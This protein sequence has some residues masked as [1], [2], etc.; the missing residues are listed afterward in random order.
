MRLP[1]LSSFVLATALSFNA[2]SI[3]ACGASS[4]VRLQESEENV[5]AIS[6]GDAA[7]QAVLDFLN[8]DATTFEILDIDVNLDARAARYLIEA[9]AGEDGEKGSVDDVAFT[10]IAQVDAV[11]YVGNAAL[12]SL[13]DFALAH[14]YGDGGG[15]VDVDAQD[16]AVL[17]LVNDEATD[18]FRLDEGAALNARAAR[19]IIAER[20]GEDALF[21][22]DDDHLFESIAALDAVSYVGEAA[23]E[24]LQLFAIA[25][26]YF[27]EVNGR[28]HD[29]I[30]SPQ[31]YPLSHNAEVRTLIESAERTLDIAMYSFSDYSIYDV[32]EEAVARGVQIRFIFETAN[33]DRKKSGSALA[34]TRSARLENMGVNVRY[35]NRIM[36]H[37][38][39]IVDGP[40]GDEEY[41]SKSTL[42]TGSGNWSYGAATRYDENTLFLKGEAGLSLSYQ[43]EFDYLWLHSRDIVIDGSLPYVMNPLT[44]TDA[45]IDDAMSGTGTDAL[46][47]SKNFSV[48]EGGTTFRK[49]GGNEVSDALVQ[50]IEAATTRIYVASGHLRL[51]AVALALEAKIAAQPDLDI[52]IV[53][54]GQEYLS[55]S[56]HQRQLQRRSDCLAVATSDAKIR[57]CYDK[58][59]LYSYQLQDAG[60]PLRYKMYSYRW[61]YT[62]AVQMHDKYMVIDDD[63]WTGSFNLSDNAEHNTFENVVHLEGERFSDLV[64]AYVE[65]YNSMWNLENDG[66]AFETLWQ[67][68]KNDD[69]IPLVF[70]PMS[71]DWDAVTAL[72]RH[73][74]D[75]C[76]DVNSEEFRKHPESHKICL[77]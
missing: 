64:N 52:R 62:Y 66:I 27:D 24:R 71:L 11:K 26:G 44:I 23:L 47:T 63:L 29:V 74:R 25:E 22:T 17:L 50:A 15:D 37:K 55:Y 61:H 38:F 36:H 41:A 12:Q 32:I 56:T 34:A 8:D 19:N 46:F 20:D 48:S 21:G 1:I 31:L 40:F 60:I 77:R 45:M 65:N 68:M 49:N 6:L 28:T 39:M 58:G 35:V 67:Q 59:F 51:R 33:S 18:F 10:S 54:D 53:L 30:F 4:D 75:N 2:V 42:A 57:N 16:Q 76:L 13:A 3:S 69:V 14:G 73:I 5:E 70:Q 43:Q 9:K 7:E 72:K